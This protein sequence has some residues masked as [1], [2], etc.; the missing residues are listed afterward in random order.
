MKIKDFFNGTISSILNNFETTE[1]DIDECQYAKLL[2][3]LVKRFHYI[4]C[5]KEEKLYIID[6][7]NKDAIEKI[8]LDDLN[9]LVLARLYTY[10]Y[11]TFKVDKYINATKAAEKYII[12]FSIIDDYE[13][14]CSCIN[15]IISISRTFRQEKYDSIIKK[16][17][18]EL[19]KIERKEHNAFELHIIQSC[20]KYDVVEYSECIKYCTNK[21]RES[22]KS[23]YIFEGYFN[24]MLGVI[25]DALK[26]NKISRDEYNK[27]QRELYILK[28]KLYEQYADNLTSSFQKSHY[29]G[30]AIQCLNYIEYDS[31]SKEFLN[32]RE[33]LEFNQSKIKENM[34]SFT[35]KNDIFEFQQLVN[36]ELDELYKKDYIKLLVYS[37]FHLVKEKQINVIKNEI[38]EY[39]LTNLFPQAIINDFGKTISKLKSIDDAK[40]LVEKEE[41]ILEYAYNKSIFIAQIYGQFINIMMNLIK[42][43]NCNLKKYL[44]GIVDCSFIVPKSRKKIVKKGINYGFDFDFESALGILIPQMENCIRELAGICGES[45]YKIGNDFVESANGLEFLLKKGNRLEQT[46][47]E[48]TYFGLCA[49]F[50]SDCGLNYRNEFSHGLIENFNNST[51][52]YVWWY[53]LYLITL[54]SSYSKYINKKRLN[55]TN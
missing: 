55:N 5:D 13:I 11:Q 25:E 46:I 53:C 28:A 27:K 14:K 36:K 22:F 15:K 43:R 50:S 47:D 2:Y 38:Q 37:G 32:L 12:S 54:Y 29:Y 18:K 23:G 48:D 24:F 16:L 33:K 10:L 40:S 21:M 44:S 26:K 7:F 6:N 35:E 34:Q 4:N 49:V 30:S 1:F 19:L 20:Y 45:K 41:I 39:P 9:P 42:K 51:A 3:D 31:Y 8:I 52:A 17:L